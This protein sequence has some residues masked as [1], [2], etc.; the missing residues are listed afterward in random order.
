MR[1]RR[2]RQVQ[3]LDSTMRIA[4]VGGC[5]VNGYG[6]GRNQGFSSVAVKILETNGI[7]CETAVL[8]P[9]KLTRI[10]G[11]AEMCKQFEPDILVLQMGHFELSPSLLWDSSGLG[12]PPSRSGLEPAPFGPDSVLRKTPLWHFRMVGK[13]IV[14][15]FSGRKL[16]NVRLFGEQLEYFVAQVAELRIPKVLVL[17]PLP[18]ADTVLMYYRRE[19][20]RAYAD[21][22]LKNGF[23]FQ[24]LLSGQ[25]E[26][27]YFADNRH[28]SKRGHTWLGKTVGAALLKLS[29]KH[30]ATEA[31]SPAR[32][33]PLSTSAAATVRNRLVS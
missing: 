24:D 14:D 11:V 30:L 33:E 9:L 12:T 4:F 19:A 13:E 27:D 20:S 8:G 29:Q 22:S 18:C 3:R 31:L 6:V 1:E 17:G 7:R 32:C 5:H 21:A 2:G 10:L 15:R 16:V 23:C 28:L 25:T 26:E